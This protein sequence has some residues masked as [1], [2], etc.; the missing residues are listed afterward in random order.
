MH[1]NM[2]SCSAGVQIRMCV[3][4]CVVCVCVSVC[5][6]RACVRVGIAKHRNHRL[7]WQ[8][9]TYLATA[10]TAWSWTL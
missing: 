9:I 6:V 5:S 8:L 1:S 4:L 2:F 10:S 7:L 3:C